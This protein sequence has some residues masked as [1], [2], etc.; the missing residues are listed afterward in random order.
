VPKQ[1]SENEAVNHNPG[2][3]LQTTWILFAAVRADV[4]DLLSLCRWFHITRFVE[5][6]LC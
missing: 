3:S 5:S 1:V 4:A 6:L 2:R